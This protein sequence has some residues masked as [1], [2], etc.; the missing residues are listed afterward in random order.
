VFALRLDLLTGRYAATSFDDRRRAEWPPHPAR[1]FS[2]LV[3]TWGEH[4]PSERPEA[5]RSAL[6]WLER[7]P[8][9]RLVADALERVS[10]RTVADAFV[11]VNDLAVVR[12]PSP[13]KRDEAEAALASAKD[14]K[15]AIKARKKLDTEVA[16]YRDAAANAA[17]VDPKGFDQT[18]IRVAAGI[19]HPERRKRQARTFPV[20]V[21]VTMSIVFAWS[22]DPPA[23]VRAALADL[24]SRVT[25]L[26]HSSSLVVARVVEAAEVA[27]LEAEI[28][29]YL[30]DDDGE[31]LLRWVGAGQLSRL[32]AAHARHQGVEPRVLPAS[33]QRYTRHRVE[34]GAPNVSTTFD[35][36]LIVLGRVGGPRLPITAA[37]GLARQLRRALISSAAEPV[38]SIISGHD[39]DGRPATTP[40][41]AYAP[42]PN[43]ATPYA[44]GALLGVA[45]CLP[46]GIRGDDRVAVLRALAALEQPD[47]EDRIIRLQ[48]GAAGVLELRREVP[49]EAGRLTTTPARWTSAS[50]RWVSATP[51][52]LDRNPGD[53]HDGNVERRAAAFAAAEL[54]VRE[55]V[56]HAAPAAADQ[57]VRVTVHRSA[58]LPGHEKPVRHPR[59]PENAA[60][61]A[62]V[63]VHVLLEF[64]TPVEGP[65]LI[66]AGRHAGLGLMLPQRTAEAAP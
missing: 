32:E 34:P 5:E 21:P 1:L 35:P 46:R 44:D 53:L 42:L 9:P 57:L 51:V 22:G 18:A 41:I 56:R 58:L 63:L 62:R 59:Y 8:A 29:A 48:L 33:F 24:A 6:D 30:P 54:V 47:G 37:P 45:L 20:V 61:P 19:D 10:H 55:A 15:A 39:A 23:E 16:R 31:H 60:R 38:P 65:L 13:V 27:A 4:E 28:G 7:Q 66:G 40:H 11:P 12:W 52:A 43:V 64:A 26:G 17:A 2:A 14:E 25:R 36:R 3:A 50:R 49:G